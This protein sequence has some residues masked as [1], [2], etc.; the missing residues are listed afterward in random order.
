MA[1]W[2]P[3]ELP[4]AYFRFFHLESST[5]NPRGLQPVPNSSLSQEICTIMPSRCS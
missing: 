2:I 5:T 3:E 1:H 4:D